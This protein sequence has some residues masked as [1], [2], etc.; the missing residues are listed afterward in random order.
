MKVI[1][2]SDGHKDKVQCG[3]ERYVKFVVSL[4]WLAGFRREGK[5]SGH[6]G[7]GL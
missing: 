2:T 6:K 4:T 3:K 1:R 7:K 5:E